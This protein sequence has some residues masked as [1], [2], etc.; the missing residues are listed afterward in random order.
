MKRVHFVLLLGVFGC[1]DDAAPLA[2]AGR[3][4]GTISVGDAGPIDSG[5]ADAA[6]PGPTVVATFDGA[7]FQLPESLAYHAGRAYLSFLNGAVVAV[8]PDGTVE[9]FGNVPIEPAGSAYGLGVA[10][11]PDGTIYLAMAKA[12]ATSEFPSGIYRIP[13]AGGTGTLFASHPELYIPNDLDVHPSGDVYV[14]A[15]GRIY[16]IT[17]AGTAEIWLEDPLLASTEARPA[18]AAC[19]PR[20]SRS[21]RTASRSRRTG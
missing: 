7:M 16:R 19:A 4:S 1:G 10:A 12:S 9:P 11:A 13:A 8:D 3:D 21:A 5:T 15:D 2:D 18:L 20:P 6:R 17:A 14:T